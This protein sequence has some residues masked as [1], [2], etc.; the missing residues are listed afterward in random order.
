MSGNIGSNTSKKVVRASERKGLAQEVVNQNRMS[1]SFDCRTFCVSETCYCY[2]AH[3][4][5]ENQ[6][7]AEQ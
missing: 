1:L 6:F 2:S 3:L 5:D 7:I 4:A